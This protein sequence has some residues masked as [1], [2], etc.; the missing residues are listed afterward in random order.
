VNTGE[1]IMNKQYRT[2]DEVIV[3]DLK[4]DPKLA[5][6]FLE[7]ISEECSSEVDQEVFISALRHIAKAK[8]FSKLARESG[9]TRDTFYKCLAP[10]GNPRLSTIMSILKALKYRILFKPI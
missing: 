10:H 5:D 9:L 3:E 6:D 1:S 4:E 8:G 7:H 2:V